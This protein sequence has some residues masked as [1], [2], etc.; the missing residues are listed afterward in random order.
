[1][2]VGSGGKPLNV[3]HR[4]RRVGNGLTEQRLSIGLEGGIELLVGAVRFHEGKPDPH[5]LHGD[6][7]QVVG[8]A[9]DG[10]GAHHVVAGRGDIEDGEEGGRL[11]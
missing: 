9:I 6:R 2:G 10:G 11:S 4:Q 5:A 8:A 7:K 3:Q 1:M